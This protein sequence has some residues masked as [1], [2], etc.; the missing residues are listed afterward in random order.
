MAS[1]WSTKPPGVNGDGW[2]RVVDVAAAQSRRRLA[3]AS[4]W[5]TK[6][7]GVNGDGWRLVVNVA[8][9][10]SRRRR[11]LVVAVAG[12]PQVTAL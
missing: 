5:S 9:A 8:A 7:R 11:R 4:P 3:M 1:P 2:R 10:Q 12:G 6:P